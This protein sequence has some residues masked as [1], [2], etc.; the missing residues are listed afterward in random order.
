MNPL[1]VAVVTGGHNY[2]VR[3]FQRLFEAMDG[4]HAFIQHM[5]EFAC[6]SHE[7]RDAYDAVVF[8]TM[9]KEGPSDEGHPWY[10]GQPATAVSH[11]GAVP[12]GIVLLHHGILAY[13][14]SPVWQALTGPIGRSRGPTNNQRIRVH[15]A[16]PAHPVTRG[17]VDWE[18]T[19]EVY[20][21]DEPGPES[22]VL[23]SVDHPKSM[24]HIAWTR[25]YQR[26][27]VFCFESGHG[28]AAWEDVNFREVLRRG[29]FWSAG[30]S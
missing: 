28:P 14:D 3:G 18:M 20:L 9:L 15:V 24:K 1:E 30:R 22:H 10:A 19:D 13:P 17:L 25:T 4:V 21:M 16:D 6:A 27:R 2:D 29:I 5:D 26:A 23:L 7:V 11:L 12:Q 8:F